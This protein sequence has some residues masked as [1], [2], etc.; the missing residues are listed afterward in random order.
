MKRIDVE[1][2]FCTE[3]YVKYFC[4]GKDIHREEIHQISVPIWHA[5]NIS[6]LRISAFTDGLFGLRI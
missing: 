4:T 2:P 1:D 3:E 6:V 5:A